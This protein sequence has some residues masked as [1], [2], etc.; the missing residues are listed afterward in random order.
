MRI[1]NSTC[2]ALFFASIFF[3]VSL[4]VF[5]YFTGGD[6]FGYRSF[7]EGVSALS[8]FDAFDFYMNSLGTMEPGYFV[9]VFI[10]SSIFDKD[11]IFSTVNFLFAY[12]GFLWLVRSR[13]SRWIVVLLC[14]NFYFFVLLFSAERLKF[15]I[16][17]FLCG[18]YCFGFFRYFFWI[19]SIFVHV[20]VVSLLVSAQSSRF[21]MFLKSLSRGAA[22][23]DFFVLMIAL[24]V[25]VAIFIILREHI[26]SKFYFYYAL[27]GGYQG[28]F[29]PVFFTL[30]A[31]I[32]AKGKWAE[33]LVAGLPII[34]LAFFVGSDRVTIISYFVFMYY[35]LN[36]RRGLN[37]AV[38]SS[39]VY[40]A[41]KGV[42]FLSNIIRFGDGFAL[43]ASG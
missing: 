41:V 27:A 31:V 37:L 3:L 34:L 33:A 19:G 30:L 7:Y 20:Q 29:K 28:L 4:Y 24:L 12:L 1:K 18:V 26:S 15:S 10:F 21:L 13:V 43:S 36:F 8:L 22:G 11:F 42:I 32:Y 40:F 9:F 35:G 38:I 39:S 2:Q 14:F 6:Q 25:L 5:P 17:F 16:L 23:F